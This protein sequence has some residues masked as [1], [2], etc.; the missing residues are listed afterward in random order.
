MHKQLRDKGV[1]VDYIEYSDTGHY[2]WLEK[3]REDFYTRLLRLLDQ[4]IGPGAKP[5]AAQP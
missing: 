5:V 1:P 4:N 3:H 2:L